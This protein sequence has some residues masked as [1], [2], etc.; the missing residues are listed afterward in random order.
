[1]VIPLVPSS[2]SAP[3][4]RSLRRS[5]RGLR[6]IAGSGLLTVFSAALSFGLTPQASGLA[7]GSRAEA[8][9][10]AVERTPEPSTPP[11]AVPPLRT[12][13][14]LSAQAPAVLAPQPVAPATAS[15]DSGFERDEDAPLAG[16][17]NGALFLRSRDSNFVFYPNGRLNI[18]A[19]FFPNRGDVRLGENNPGVQDGVNDQRPRDTIFIR[20]ARA[21]FNGTVLKHFDYML[22]GEFAS[23]PI[24]F[25]SAQISDVFVNV[26]YTPWANIQ[27]GQFDAPFT[28]ENRTVDKYIDFMERS[29]TVRSFAVP[30]NKEIGVMVHGMAPQR[31]L[32]YEA[33]IFNGDG[34]NVRNPDNH[35]DVMGRAYFAPLALL[36]R[37]NAT[38]WLSEIWVGASFWYGQRVD[39]PY[40]AFPPLSSNAAVVFVP[41]VFGNGNRLV[42][43]G[44]ILKW[45]VEVNVPIGPIGW[46]FELVRSERDGIGIYEPKAGDP[47]NTYPL[48]R[49]LSGNINRR[50]TSFYLQMWYWILGSPS[51]L[52]TAG[53]ELPQRWAGFKKGKESFPIGLYVSVRYERMFAEHEEL[54]QAGLIRRRRQPVAVSP[55]ALLGQ[56]LPQLSR[57]H[58]AGDLGQRALPTGGSA[59]AAHLP[60]LSHARARDP[61]PRRP[62]PLSPAPHKP[63]PHKPAPRKHEAWRMQ[64]CCPQPD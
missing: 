26:N 9:E 21:E 30:M 24:M 44:S 58:H 49:T 48:N 10:A 27:I 19:F 42:P 33:G 20:R 41:P 60:V 51:M 14:P 56:L 16:Y 22:A 63:A 5:Q 1:V 57:R 35:F 64:L 40:D 8:E 52:P 4:T 61:V 11:S 38:R 17:T 59:D 2:P 54:A 39:V 23:I 36:Q 25:Q 47:A 29:I 3:S 31:F 12:A 50:G 13:V 37:A 18:D 43:N 45:A 55:R 34:G 15:P 28:L 6:T 62:R 53:Q 32:R 7:L 46:R